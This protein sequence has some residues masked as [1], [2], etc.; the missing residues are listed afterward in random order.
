VGVTGTDE[1]V[2][3]GFP[4]SNARNG[5]FA[6]HTWNTA[7][8]RRIH[9]LSATDGLSNTTVV[10]ERPPSHDRGWGWWPT[11]DF[12]SLLANPNREV[13]IVTGCPNPGFFRPDIVSNR[14]A[15]T[16]YWSLH[17]GGGNWLMGDGAVRFYSYNAGTTVLPALASINGGE[18]V[19]ET[20]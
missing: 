14:C 7:R 18:V 11:S 16:H 20:N 1:W 6:V 17:T 10:G 19:S 4:G 12:D 2:E 15:V 3:S 8:A 5:M 9:M 13:A